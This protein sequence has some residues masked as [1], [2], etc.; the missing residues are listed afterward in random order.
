MTEENPTPETQLAP[1]A[2]RV[3]ANATFDDEGLGAIKSFEDAAQALAGAGIA[4]ERSSDY[5]NG[6]SVLTDKNLLVGQD[7]LILDWRWNTGSFGDGESEGAFVSAQIIT[8]ANEKWIL[9]D[10]STG[11]CQQLI[12]VTETR[13]KNAYSRPQTG[14]IVEGGLTASTYFVSPKDGSISK[15]PVKGWTPA[16]TFYL[17][18]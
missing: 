15:S 10:G 18:E 16:T 1:Q 12:R 5:G 9:N 2:T 4:V 17:A 8:K 7:F 14:L 13:I 3:N 11:I 6:F